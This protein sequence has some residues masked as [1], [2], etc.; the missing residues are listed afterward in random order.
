[1]IRL[2]ADYDIHFILT[3]KEVVDALN[4]SKLF[5]DECRQFV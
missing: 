4:D 2:Y 1:M 3:E 5:V